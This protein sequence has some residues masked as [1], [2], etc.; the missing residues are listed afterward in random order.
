MKPVKP[1]R[2]FDTSKSPLDGAR[3]VVTGASR[4]VGEAIARALTEAGAT[5]AL[6]ARSKEALDKVASS[7]GRR[8][9]VV[10]CDLTDA[11]SVRDAVIAIP[12]QLDG[13]PN[14]VVNCA[15]VFPFAP[16][17]ELSEEQFT[18][19]VS[20][21][22]VAPFRFVRAFLPAMQ[23]AGAGHIVSIGS[24]ADRS[25]FSANGA[26]AATKFGARAL[27]EV[28]RSETRGTGIRASLVSPGP[29]DTNLWDSLDPD[30]RDDLPSR[31]NMLRADDV[32]NAVLF[33]LTQPA[34]VN[35]DE[36]RLSRS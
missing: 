17:H 7:L 4:G 20:I 34:G 25:A 12:R 30:A 15:G 21:N 6:V 29:T 14:I 22:L 10:Q 26:Y 16:M 31:S 1:V 18:E 23:A 24:V 27:H 35:I 9:R 11:A 3:A 2:P 32:A 13:A 33:A 28:L 19:A 36:L 8:A 5:V